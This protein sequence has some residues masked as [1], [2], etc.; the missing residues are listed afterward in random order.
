MSTR[1]PEPARSPPP[2]LLQ[3]G[4]AG[5]YRRGIAVVGSTIFY[6]V[7]NSGS[8]FL[9]STSGTDFGVAFNTGLPGI[10]SITSDGQFL[11]LTPSNAPN[12]PA[13]S[14][15]VYKYTFGG[16]LLGTTLLRSVDRTAEQRRQPYG[17]RGRRERFCRQPR[18]QRRPLRPIRCNW[19]AADAGLYSR[20]VRGLG[21]DVR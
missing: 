6:S 14:E 16:T 12:N 9:T 13:V 1:R 17:A 7:D 3:C 19:R 4:S 18:Q 21:S 15:N 10:G 20:G 11:Y 8:V 5:P 2:L